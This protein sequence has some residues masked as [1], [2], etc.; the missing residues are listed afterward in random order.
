[1]KYLPHIFSLLVTLSCIVT[2]A[3]TPDQMEQGRAIAY[4]YCL[5]NL[6]NGSGYLDNINPKTVTELESKLTGVEK[7]NINMLKSIPAPNESDFSD[8]GKDEFVKY[9]SVDF[10]NSAN[11]KKQF[12]VSYASSQ[13]KS[14][15]GNV[16]VTVQETK[17]AEEPAQEDAQAEEASTDEL[18]QPVDMQED[19]DINETVEAETQEVTPP[20]PVPV[21]KKSDNTA[22]IIVLCVLVV[23]VVILVGYALNI[24]KKNRNRTMRAQHSRRVSDDEEEEEEE[25]YPEPA[26]KAPRPAHTQH[27]ARTTISDR[28]VARRAAEEASRYAP[29]STVLNDP[30]DESPFAAYSNFQPEQEPE[31]DGR[32]R[33]IARL[34]AEIAALKSQV[35]P[36]SPNT[37]SQPAR[38]PRPAATRRQ[39]PRII[40]LTEANSEGVFKGASAKFIDGRSIFKLVTTDGVSG[41]FSVIENPEV[42]DIAL[43]MPRDFLI[44]A[45]AGHNLLNNRGATSIINEAS[46]T[47]IFEDGRWRVIRKAQIRYAG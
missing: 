27:S 1:M 25:E 42:F 41:S 36:S 45:C 40:Y 7:E 31:P 15:L 34:K 22:A 37:M 5:R 47:A 43:E 26:E 18:E 6:N 23:I 44:H 33:E 32:D 39:Q 19:A 38:A 35:N 2:H 14:K 21:K 30:E 28:Y 8:W 20:A 3:A 16:A 10:P 13:I 11:K 4:K 24:M 9:W 46:G 12:A 29:M 17:P